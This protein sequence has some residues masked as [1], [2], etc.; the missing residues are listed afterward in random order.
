MLG[1]T[2]L[3][4]KKSKP[5]KTSS[6]LREKLAE[7]NQKQVA[8]INKLS[9]ID[10]EIEPIYSRPGFGSDRPEGVELRDALEEIRRRAD[11]ANKEKRQIEGEIEATKK[12]LIAVDGIEKEKALRDSLA[13]ADDEMA[14]A[15]NRRGDL[16]SQLAK[17]EERSTAMKQ[18]LS[19]LK[20][21]LEI[22][23][24][25]FLTAKRDATLSDRPTPKEPAD[26]LKIRSSYLDMSSRLSIV[27]GEVATVT[28]QFEAAKTLER[29][30]EIRCLDRNYYEAQ[31]A[32]EKLASDFQAAEMVFGEAVVPIIK[33]YEATLKRA[34]KLGHT[35]RGRPFSYRTHH[36]RSDDTIYMITAPLSHRDYE[37]RAVV[38]KS[39]ESN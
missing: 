15:T 24:S 9:S 35:F 18:S 38:K 34:G 7:L 20:S 1:F 33:S 16:R 28:E 19:T 22:G 5:D 39:A 6:E 29:E 26:L 25:N 21:E 31:A 11:K 10:A 12:E 13:N 4:G 32:F 3:N 30:A 14:K 23:E 27:E 8:I 2:F 37:V 36:T 17:L